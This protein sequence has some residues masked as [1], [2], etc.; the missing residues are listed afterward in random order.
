MNGQMLGQTS[1]ISDEI[2]SLRGIYH[3]MSS[4]NFKTKMRMLEWL[5]KRFISDEEVTHMV[6]RQPL[7][8]GDAER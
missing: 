3:E 4:F 1:V 7:T 8:K 5:T 6:A 2:D